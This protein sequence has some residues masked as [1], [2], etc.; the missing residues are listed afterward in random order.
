MNL[1]SMEQIQCQIY[2]IRGH[3]IMLDSHLA[4]LYGVPT[5][6]LNRAVKRNTLRF[7]LD[8]MFKLTKA[9]YGA[10]RCQFGI[11]EERPYARYLPYVFTQ[12]GVAMLS[13]VLH[14][15]RAVMVNVQIMRAFVRLRDVGDL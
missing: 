6:H 11:L 13:S 3:K 2:F 8:F 5:G 7:P 14:S 10:L 4:N 1:L 9:E 15:E 12:E